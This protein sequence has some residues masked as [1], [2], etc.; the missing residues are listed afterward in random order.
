MFSSSHTDLGS[1][2]GKIPAPYPCILGHEGAGEVVKVGKDYISQFS[3]GDFVVASFCSC[4]SCNSC[5]RIE[6]ACCDSFLPLNLAFLDHSMQ[7]VK[8]SYQ[9]EDKQPKQAYTKYFG[10]SSF[11]NLMPVSGRSVSG[12]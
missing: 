12:I 7:N 4:G 2:S 6:P 11:A 8:V 10:Q 1:W 5:K 3:K 9:T